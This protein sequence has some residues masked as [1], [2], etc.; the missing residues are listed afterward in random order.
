MS[1]T[2]EQR[3]EFHFSPA[4]S[5]TILCFAYFQNTLCLKLEF[6]M[7]FNIRFQSRLLQWSRS[8]PWWQSVSVEMCC[9]FFSLIL[10]LALGGNGKFLFFLLLEV[11]MLIP[12]RKKKAI[13]I[14]VFFICMHC[15]LSLAWDF[16]LFLNAG[17]VEP[18]GLATVCIVYVGIIKDKFHSSVPSLVSFCSPVAC[19]LCRYEL[20]VIFFS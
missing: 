18:C 5:I 15:G 7:K 2:F 14:A 6:W 20:S 4:F 1:P 13:N 10:S 12:N 16:C 3:F 9:F 19:S 11:Y 17:Q 8:E